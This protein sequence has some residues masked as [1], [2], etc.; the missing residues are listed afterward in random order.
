MAT[1]VGITGSGRV[2]AVNAQGVERAVKEGDVLQSGETIRTAGDSRVEL[3]MDDGQLMQVNRD[4][5]VKIDNHVFQTEDTPKAADAAVLAPDTTQTVI[6]ALN[7]GTDL[8]TAL[9]SR[10]GWMVRG[11]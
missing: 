5:S 1:I 10:A 6:Q 11:P 2:F 4:Q 7:S 9:E 8:S 3:L